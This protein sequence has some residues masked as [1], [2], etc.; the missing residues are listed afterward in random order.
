[1]RRAVVA[2]Q[3][4]ENDFQ[5]LEKQIKDCF[6][7]KQGPGD[8]PIKTRKGNIIGVIAPH[9]GYSFSGQCA[10]WAYKEIA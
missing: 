8:L 7:L 6:F 3:F 10:A 9:A 4:Y 1:M 5:K 2:G